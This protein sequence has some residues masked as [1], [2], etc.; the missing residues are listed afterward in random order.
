[1]KMQYLRFSF[2]LSLALISYLLSYSEPLLA[3]Q[4]LGS[5]VIDESLVKAPH[6]NYLSK[7]SERQV[8][9][10]LSYLSDRNLTLEE[11][12]SIP[13]S[14]YQ[15]NHSDWNF[16]EVIDDSVWH[17]IEVNNDTDLTQVRMLTYSMPTTN[18]Y[19][20]FVTQNGKVID[21]K[22]GGNNFTFSSREI[23]SRFYS[24]LFQ[25]EPRETQVIYLNLR[26]AIYKE[27]RIFI[28]TIPQW[29]KTHSLDLIFFMLVF[30]F[31]FTFGIYHVF[32]FI[33]TREQLYL[34]FALMAFA[35]LITSAMAEN[36]V[37]YVWSGL[38]EV[39]DKARVV[40]I[41]FFALTSYVYFLNQLNITKN[42]KW[43]YGLLWTLICLDVGG[44]LLKLV[45][46]V[47][48][49]QWGIYLGAIGALVSL[50]CILR[51]IL[52][53]QRSAIFVVIS[54]IPSSLGC[55]YVVFY[56]LLGLDN[57]WGLKPLYV[58][59]VVSGLF[60]SFTVADTINL[61][62]RDKNKAKS[63]ALSAE[64]ETKAKSQF[65]AQMSHE[66]RT[67][68]NGVLGMSEL[69][70]DTGLNANQQQYLDV[71]RGSG[72]ALLNVINDI[73]DYSKIEAGKLDIDNIAYD[74]EVLVSD[75]VTIFA[76]TASKKKIALI[77]SVKPGTQGLVVGDPLR[78]R[79]ILL[80]LLSNAFKFTSQGH[81]L[82]RVESVANPKGE[83]ELLKFEVQDSGIGISEKN[84]AKLFQSFNQAES[85]TARRF[86]GTGLGLAISKSLSGLMGGEI[87]IDSEE[88]KGSTFWFTVEL[89]PP[90]EEQLQ[91]HNLQTTRNK[92][93]DQALAGKR[94]L[95]VDDNPLYIDYLKERVD[96]W[97]MSFDTCYDADSALELLANSE[98]TFD[99][100]SLDYE[101]PGKNGLQCATAIRQID[102]Y[103]DCPI[104]LLTA[105]R[106]E[107]EKAV[108]EAAGVDEAMGKPVYPGML[109]NSYAR[110]L[111]IQVSSTE[112]QA[113]D[114]PL[115][116]F[117]LYVLVA[118]DNQVNQMVIKGLLH[119][120]GIEPE[121][122]NDGQ[123][124]L[125]QYVR[126]HAD[127]DLV[128]M[129]CEMPELDGYEASRQIREY[130]QDHHMLAK[131]IY[132]LS[133][134]AMEET[135]KRSLE[136]G[137]DG[138]I[139]KP[140]KL[141]E[142]VSVLQNV[143]AMKTEGYKKIYRG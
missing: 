23:E 9:G 64:A 138:H 34:S 30:G 133:A 26:D 76:L 81:V 69:L 122:V 74:L 107:L 40:S 97:G 39:M 115:Q 45:F 125:D 28:E 108:I 134:H 113:N 50:A 71:I 78:I 129:D 51:R 142:L 92:E 67:P 101:M 58:S 117:D 102:Q 33:T 48:V 66:I 27:P 49:M 109:K 141:E 46:D 139:V 52:L 143:E 140:I 15:R 65:L 128:L 5:V 54:T 94:V 90:T 73:L 82:L 8:I 111:N 3:K 43:E 35:I 22:S 11:I 116:K 84:Q 87:G 24:H 89:I 120:V 12:L 29:N 88:G 57:A 72:E 75:A 55:V 56:M 136:A 20:L 110:L 83:G 32:L 42:D 79:Q 25:V 98:E 114:K 7:S 124:A 123:E 44:I 16:M 68:M 6:T 103:K 130:E 37:S 80:N 19:E 99:L 91:S 86:G 77:A 59:L 93:L 18:W 41:Y 135:V 100:I 131:P 62:K 132:A 112:P 137:M 17:R 63:L 10:A 127:I 1:M 53:G 2:L 119:K 61:L 106:A 36:F 96:G 118:E 60:L 38:P 104:L 14:N 21:Q 31:Y 126:D 85:S 105:M 13:L 121:I 70:N 4:P 95:L 47:G